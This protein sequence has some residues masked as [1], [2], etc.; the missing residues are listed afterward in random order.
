[1]KKY[2]ELINEIPNDYFKNKNS[3]NYC[4]YNPPNLAA[5]NIEN[6]HDNL[7]EIIKEYRRLEEMSI[8]I[9]IP[10]CGSRCAYCNYFL[11]L[12]DD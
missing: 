4:F 3:D 12:Y 5:A 11:H 8:Y 10:F 1:M 2:Q 6:T 9:N 7:S